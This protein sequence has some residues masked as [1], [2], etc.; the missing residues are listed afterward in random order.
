MDVETQDS[1][2]ATIN[3]PTTSSAFTI[4]GKSVLAD[5]ATQVANQ[6]GLTG[7]TQP[8]DVALVGFKI[9]PT[10]ENLTWSDLV[11]SL[12]YGGGMADA[13][14]TSAR[15][16]VDNGTVGTY[17][18]G[19]DT[20]VGAQSVNAASGSLTWTTVGGAITAATDYLIIF[21]AGAS[22][23]TN[24]TVQASVTAANITVTGVTSSASITTSGS[25]SNEPLHTVTAPANSVYRALN[26]IA[27]YSIDAACGTKNTF[28]TAPTVRM[29]VDGNEP[30]QANEDKISLPDVP[31]SEVDVAVLYFGTGYSVDTDVAGMASGHDINFK[32]K[33][34]AGTFRLY[35]IEADPSNGDVLQTFTDGVY[36]QILG[37]GDALPSSDPDLSALTGRVSTGNIFGFKMTFEADAGGVADPEVKFGGLGSGKQLLFNVSEIAAITATLTGTLADD[38]FESQ[39]VDGGETLIITLAA[40]TWDG[41]VGANNAVTTALINGLVGDGTEWNT[42]VQGGLSFSNVT[43]DTD[44]QVTILLPVFA[45][46]DITATETITVT[47]PA[48]ALVTSSSALIATPT[49]QITVE[50]PFAC[51]SSI[52]I[53]KDQVGLDNTGT[54]PASGF[55]VLISLSGDWLKTTAVDPV[56]G[57][58]ENANGYDIVFRES[59]GQTELDHEIEDYDGTAG[60]L[61]AWVRIDSLS[62]SADTTIYM[63]YGNACIDFATQDPDNLWD[64]NF[65]GVWHLKEAGGIYDDSAGSNDGTQ[66]GNVFAAGKMAGGQLFDG[67]NDYVDLPD[68]SHDFSGAF[69]V[70]LWAKWDDMSGLQNLISKDQDGNN[71]A[72]VLIVNAAGK[73]HLDIKLGGVQKNSELLSN[74]VYGGVRRRPHPPG[75]R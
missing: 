70:S 55:P 44:T 20:Q 73:L 32:A 26:I 45:G 62:K 10:G 54:L 50:C 65:K 1:G 29:V 9:T 31:A 13:D 3:G 39:I 22:L 2:S 5:P 46:Y 49:F 7:G 58:I 57:R 24:E 59:D 17:D 30:C 69:S 14:I 72:F 42:V 40:D 12:T 25:V 41:T 68:G 23:S 51:R 37:D 48:S 15:I 67:D 52:V 34:G 35:L 8:T 36:V 56:N 21:D 43:R 4:Q 61:V 71:F 47:V 6:L 28:T 19:T 64:A 60:T 38:A 63:Y 16:Y 11:V 27:D 53:N 18:S 33:N 74:V 66:N 75:L